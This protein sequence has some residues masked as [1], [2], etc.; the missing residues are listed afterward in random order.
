M[1][2]LILDTEYPMLQESEEEEMDTFGIEM[3]HWVDTGEFLSFRLRPM[4]ELTIGTVLKVVY[5]HSK[6]RDLIFSSFNP[7]ICLLL[8]LK[9]VC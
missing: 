5:D 8:S 2:M 1:R 3:N 9:Q 6:G 4:M 7:D